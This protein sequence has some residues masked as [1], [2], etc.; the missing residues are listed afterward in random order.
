MSELERRKAAVIATRTR[1][2]ARPFA[3]GRVDCVRVAAWHLRQ[4]GHKPV[5]LAKAGS[6]RSALGARRALTR[7]GH[8][9]LADAVAAIGL[10]ERAPAAAWLGDLLVKPGTDGL[11]AIGIVAGSSLVLGF[12]QDQEAIDML[13]LVD[14]ADA[15]AFHL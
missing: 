2:A 14:F 12:H 15:R 5:G 6:Y 11:D 8:A 9:T 3:F 7:A 10:E 4:F 13:R 1:F